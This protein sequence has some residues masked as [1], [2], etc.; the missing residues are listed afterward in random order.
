MLYARLVSNGRKCWEINDK[1]Y[2]LV[3]TAH[4]ALNVDCLNNKVEA[5]S[6]NEEAHNLG[7]CQAQ[8]Y[9]NL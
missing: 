7:K 3:Q 8:L 4:P 5:T 6:D 1:G 9:N 2:F